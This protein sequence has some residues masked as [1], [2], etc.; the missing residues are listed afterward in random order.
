[1]HNLTTKTIL[2]PESSSNLQEQRKQN[3]NDSKLPPELRCLCEAHLLTCGTC[4]FSK[5]WSDWKLWWKTKKFTIN[6]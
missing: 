3:T 4:I 1:M 6:N 2:H 5:M